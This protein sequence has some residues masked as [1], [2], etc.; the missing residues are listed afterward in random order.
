MVQ[1][2]ELTQGPQG[3]QQQ[4]RTSERIAL[5]TQDRKTL[6]QLGPRLLVVS[7]LRPYPTWKG[8]KPFIQMAWGGVQSTLEIKGLQRIGLRYVNRI[9]L[10]PQDVELSEYFEFYP[11]IGSDLPQKMANFI[12]GAEFPYVEGRDR[13]RVLLTPAADC[14]EMSTFMLDIDYFLTRPR[15][16][17]VSDA[18]DWVEEAHNR[19]QEVFE[20]CITD[21]LREMFEEK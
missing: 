3:L 15:A 10:A 9:E 2:V 8:F 18:L 7:V 17:E 1:E 19:V 21:A 13:C 11:F 5:F 6:V 14:E 12:A 16:I 20:G 4:I